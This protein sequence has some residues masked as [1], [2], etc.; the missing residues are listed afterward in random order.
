MKKRILSFLISTTLCLSSFVTAFANISNDELKNID[1]DFLSVHYGH[2][3]NLDN[4]IDL[5]GEAHEIIARCYQVDEG[6]YIIIST[7][8]QQI[9]EFSLTEKNQFLVNNSTQYYYGGPLT[10][11]ENRNGMIYDVCTNEK[12]GMV[13]N[14][15]ELLKLEPSIES[16]AAANSNYA[17]TTYRPP[18]YFYNVQNNCGS[19][20]VAMY[21][22]CLDKN[23]NNSYVPS[24]LEP[25][26]ADG[27]LLIKHF[28]PWIDSTGSGSYVGDVLYGMR[29]FLAQNNMG[30]KNVTSVNGTT[31]LLDYIVGRVS[32]NHPYI[33]D[34]KGHPTYNNHWVTGYGYSDNF[35]IVNNGWGS[36]G[37]YINLSYGASLVYI[38]NV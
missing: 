10:Y 21:F 13:N 15:I 33:L 20:A 34:I 9:V 26:T 27:Q 12:V 30:S 5:Y 2:S 24:N 36:N 19:V 1:S 35:A 29:Q 7:D 16:K 22:M 17:V 8:D 4:G 3:I 14:I 11:L 37:I 25:T 38:T 6:G 23:F 28:I 31:G 32:N 18:I